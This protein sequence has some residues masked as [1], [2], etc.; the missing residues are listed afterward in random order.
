MDE[1]F[2]IIQPS[3]ATYSSLCYE[4]IIAITGWDVGEE[5]DGKDDQK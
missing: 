4:K 5:E 1:Y 3:G 2:I